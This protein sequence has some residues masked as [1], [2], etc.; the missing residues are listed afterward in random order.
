MKEKL[1]SRFLPFDHNQ[2]VYRRFHHLKQKV[3]QSVQDYTEEFYQL[4]SRAQVPASEKQLVAR[5]VR[6]LKPM[7]QDELALIHLW[8]MN[9]AYPTALKAEQKLKRFSFRL[10]RGNPSKASKGKVVIGTPRNT[11][12][13][14]RQVCTLI[15]DFGSCENI[16]STEM[17]E[18]LKLK[19]E[20]HP[21]PYKIGWFKMGGELPKGLPPMRDI[22]HQIDLVLGASLPNLPDY[23]ISPAEHQELQK[24]V[25]KG[26][27]HESISPVVVPAVLTP[28][29]V[30]LGECV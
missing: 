7:L 21:H 13:Q 17:I 6:G 16:V 5:Y 8:D 18:K 25:D 15:I 11:S 19:T 29:K 23:R 26:F 14:Y 9:E 10:E 28:K 24:Q 1:T 27:I 12:L 4:L 22:Q 20:K 2:S 30:G 3:D